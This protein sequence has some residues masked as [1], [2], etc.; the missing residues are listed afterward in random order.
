MPLRDHLGADQHGPVHPAK[1]L[2]RLAQRTG[3]GRGI[4]V[5]PHPLQLRHVALELL[6]EPLRSGP[7]V[8]ELDRAAG[9]ARLGNGLSV[10]TVVAVQPAVAVQRQRD[11]AVRAAPREPTGTAVECGRDTAPVEEQDR[12]A[13]VLGETA[14]LRQERRRERVAVLAAEVDDTH[15]RHRRPDPDGEHDPLERRPALRTRRRAPV[16]RDG[17]FEGGPLR[18]HGARVV[19]R[20]G[21]LLVGGVVLLVDDH[22]P[23]VAHRREDR[24]ARADDDP[25]LAAGDAVALVAP[26]GLAERRVEDRDG[27]AESLPEPA[28]RLRRERDLR[29][30]HDRAEPTVERRLA[31]LEVHLRL[32]APGRA[33]EEEM[34]RAALVEPATIRAI[35]TSCSGVS[36]RGSASPGSDSRS[37]GDGRSPRGVR[38]SGATS[39]SARAGV[40]P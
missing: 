5:E 28:D 36:S 38:R 19:A 14:E 16:D 7:D 9:R 40:V 8:R 3:P 27:V 33:D 11:V 34:R 29:H 24:R 35:A 39:S 6:L 31:G 30:E 15:P 26:L 1:A 4:G 23:D 21:L 10:P 17:A 18:C 20:I 12:L 2:E 13:A 37:T 25:R 22:E 32:A